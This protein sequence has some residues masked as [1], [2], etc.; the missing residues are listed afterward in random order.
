MAEISAGQV[1]RFTP[2]GRQSAAIAM[3][4]TR[5]T[6]VA[7]GG[8]DLRTLFITSMQHGL[9]E[10]ELASQPQAGCLF[11]VHPSVTGLAEPRFAG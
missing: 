11:A 7:F 6:S 8:P 9:S 3:P 1:V 4:L 2:D 10:A 5:P